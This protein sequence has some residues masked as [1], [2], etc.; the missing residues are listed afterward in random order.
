MTGEQV[1]EQQHEGE[2]YLELLDLGHLAGQTITTSSGRQIQARDF[3]EI[4]GDEAIPALQLLEGLD[5]H[6]DRYKIVKN[7][8]RRS[9]S[10]YLGTDE[11]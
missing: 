7:G 8:L 10:K 11:I 1:G 2:H 3:L 4:C 6:D 9:V 5:P